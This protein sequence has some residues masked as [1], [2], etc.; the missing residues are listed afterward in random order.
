MSQKY[1]YHRKP[2]TYMGIVRDVSRRSVESLSHFR[3]AGVFIRVDNDATK[4]KY[5]LFTVQSGIN[6]KD[7]FIRDF[8]GHVEKNEHPIDAAIREFKEESLSV[9]EQHI[10]EQMMMN[11]PVHYNQDNLYIFITIK[12]INIISLIKRFDT[13]R[14]L[15]PPDCPACMKETQ[16]IMCINRSSIFNKIKMRHHVMEN[17]IYYGPNLWKTIRAFSF[18]I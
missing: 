14:K 4:E 9:F 17:K 16:T 11:A 8:G 12:N 7:E 2:S 3:R 18:V 6:P 15:L 13:C 5:Y 10:P 1:Y